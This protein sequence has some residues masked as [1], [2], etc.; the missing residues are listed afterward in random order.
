MD[1]TAKHVSFRH[2]QPGSA[3]EL[4]NQRNW[5]GDFVMISW[6]SFY[7]NVGTA[8]SMHSSLA[9]SSP[10]LKGQAQSS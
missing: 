2:V 7:V 6:C 1:V 3:E 10:H 9:L 8:D 4:N 5:W